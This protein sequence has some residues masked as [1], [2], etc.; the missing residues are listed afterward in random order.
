M[1]PCFLQNEEKNMI[2]TLCIWNIN[3]NKF[4]MVFRNISDSYEENITQKN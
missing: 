2:K 1:T 4:H 3:A